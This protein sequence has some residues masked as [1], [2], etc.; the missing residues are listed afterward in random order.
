MKRQHILLAA[1]FLFAFCFCSFGGEFY[2]SPDGSDDWAG[3]RLRPFATLAAGRDAGRALGEPVEVYL[4]GGRYVLSDT[5]ELDERD[6]KTVYK[7]F[8]NEGVLITGGFEAAVKEL[9]AVS[10]K[11]VAD[12]L[13]EEVR[14]KVVELAL[15]G[16]GKG[17]PEKWP[18]RFRGYAGWPEVYV[19]GKAMRLAR[20]PNEGYARIAKLLDK[21]SKPRNNEKPDRGGRFVYSEDNPGKWDT[22]EPVYLGGYWCFKWYDEF[23]RVESIDP[24]KKE[25]QMAAPHQYGLGGP[26]KGLYFAVNLL[27]ELDQPGEYVYDGK[28]GK[29]YLYLPEEAGDVLQ[30]SM[31]DKPLVRVKGSKE[32]SFEGI[33]RAFWRRL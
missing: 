4:R 11:S 7:A 9:K 26:S 3:S 25:I 33:Q 2:V 22:D 32:V 28:R 31:L 18:L 27:E 10:D 6:S 5:F 29:L 30:I 17:G 19:G 1:M 15:P 21:G 23:V 14:G 13:A 8:G 24:E 12:R 16:E 20:W